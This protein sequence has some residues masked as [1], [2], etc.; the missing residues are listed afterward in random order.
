MAGGSR[1]ALEDR[2][3]PTRQRGTQRSAPITT[4]PGATPNPS[5]ALKLLYCADL[6]L[7]DIECVRK[8]CATGYARA[9]G[10]THTRHWQSQW[11]TTD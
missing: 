7:R 9:N 1:R 11:H 6:K 8:T 2:C 3:S 10:N 5:R 4:F